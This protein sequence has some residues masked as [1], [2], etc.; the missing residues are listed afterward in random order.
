MRFPRTEFFIIIA[1]FFISVVGY[2]QDR[3]GK[4]TI[5]TR[6]GQVTQIDTV[7]GTFV[8]QWLG[9]DDGMGYHE[10]T[11]SVSPSTQIIKG[12]DRIGFMDIN[13]F[14]NVVVRYVDDNS[15]TPVAVSIVVNNNM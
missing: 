3:S 10:M 2:C 12:M 15:A 4:G 7:G 14:D 1:V 5:M 9:W 8:I 6:E 13:Q 11:L